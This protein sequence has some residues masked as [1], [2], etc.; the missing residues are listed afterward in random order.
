LSQHQPND[1]LVLTAPERDMS[2]VAPL[3]IEVIESAFE[4]DA[5]LVADARVGTNWLEMERFFAG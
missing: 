2:D 1:E 5:R 3:V 4:L